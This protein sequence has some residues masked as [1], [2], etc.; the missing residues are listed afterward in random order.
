MERC[1]AEVTN[2]P[3][4]ERVTFCFRWGLC[5]HDRELHIAWGT[6][7]GIALVLRWLWAVGLAAVSEDALQPTASRPVPHLLPQERSSHVAAVHRYNCSTHA[8]C[9]VACIAA[10]KPCLPRA[11]TCLTC[12]SASACHDTSPHFPK[13][14]KL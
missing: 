5:R 14:Q 4:G 10:R 1:I 3:W 11:V 7:R 9:L 13:P 2:T 6:A 12:S 8:S